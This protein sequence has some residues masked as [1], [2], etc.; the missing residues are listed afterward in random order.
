METT[1]A[2]VFQYTQPIPEAIYPNL[3]AGIENILI[4]WNA[5]GTL[6]GAEWQLL[7]G[8]FLYIRLQPDSYAASGCSIDSLRKQIHQLNTE[9]NLTEAHAGR[10]FF[11]S[12][13]S[14][15]SIEWN[16]IQQAAQMGKLQPETLVADISPANTQLPEQ[17][18]RPLKETWIAKML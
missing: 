1:T 13:H 3:K 6:L 7:E 16:E 18:F 5:H 17:V 14:L 2:W 12:E 11:K 15:E 4:K 9:L 8:Q 10:I